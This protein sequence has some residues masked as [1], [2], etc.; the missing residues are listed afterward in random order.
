M[1]S[2]RTQFSRGNGGEI[3]QEEARV[4]GTVK[5]MIK[6]TIVCLATLGLGQIMG[7]HTGIGWMITGTL[8]SLGS[9]A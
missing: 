4:R 7:I 3:R 9:E 6:T 1:A 2:F 8:V 5:A